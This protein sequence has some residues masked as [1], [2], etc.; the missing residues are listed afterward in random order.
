MVALCVANDDAIGAELQLVELIAWL[1]FHKNAE[2]PQVVL[3]FS[4]KPLTL[5]KR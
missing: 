3:A 5:R 2:A 1:A 4:S